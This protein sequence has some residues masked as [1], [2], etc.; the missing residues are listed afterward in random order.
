MK[1]W[2]I[3]ALRKIMLISMIAITILFSTPN[4][5]KAAI[6]DDWGGTLLDAV[7]SLF[8]AFGDTLTN[9]MEWA[10]IGEMS[11]EFD[12]SD[13]SW[14]PL[15]SE[16]EQYYGPIEGYDFPTEYEAATDI[17]EGSGGYRVPCIDYS[18]RE[19][20]AGVIPA[21]DINFISPNYEGDDRAIS[22]QLQTT[23][24][25]WYVG[26]R[27]FSLL[28][29]MVVLVYVGIRMMLTSLAAEKAKYKQMFLDWLIAMCLIFFLHYIMSFTITMVET[30]TDA[31]ATNVSDINVYVYPDDAA[32]DVAQSTGEKGNPEAEFSTNLTGLA[33]FR[34]Q[35]SSG[36]AKFMYLI[37]YTALVIYTLMFTITYL[38]RVLIMAFLTLVAPLV[39]MTYPIDKIGD[40][41]AQ[42]FSFWLK[43]YI[44]NALLQPFH[45]LLYAIF[46]GSAFDLATKNVIYSLVALGF[47]FSAEK[48]LR[49]MFGF[50][51]SG[52]IGTLGAF[53][54]GA[55][56]SKMIDTMGKVRGPNTQEV[57]Q[58]EKADKIKP[59]NFSNG[60]FM[61]GNADMDENTVPVIHGSGIPIPGLRGETTPVP[62]SEMTTT[63]N[64]TMGNST[65][66]SFTDSLR[67][68]QPEESRFAPGTA[69]GGKVKG[70][71]G[72]VKGIL[73]AS[74]RG[75]EGVAN[76]VSYQAGRSIKNAPKTLGKG[77]KFVGKTALRAG[78]AAGAGSIGLAAGIATGDL[79]NAI[80][81]GV[82][83]VVAGGAAGGTAFNYGEKGV[84]SAWQGAKDNIITPY[85]EGALGI[86]EVKAQRAFRDLNTQDTRNFVA[87]ETRDE[88]TGEYL[89]EEEITARIQEMAEIQQATGVYGKDNLL[90]ASDLRRATQEK[91]RQ[92][93]DA[94]LIEDEKWLNKKANISKQEI[95]ELLQ[96]TEEEKAQLRVAADPMRNKAESEMNA[97]EKKAFK[98]NVRQVEALNKME[99]L[100]NREMLYKKAEQL[101]NDETNIATAMASQTRGMAEEEKVQYI[102][103][104]CMRNG[105]TE[106]TAKIAT[107]RI[108]SNMDFL[109]GAKKN[110]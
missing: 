91:Y 37:I 56:V 73:G 18:P 63:G 70:I 71:P 82:A 60:A 95:D 103:N 23:I 24:A 88:D 104:R 6:M 69:E 1:R 15:V 85:Q 35:Y 45:L 75:L 48:I 27:N 107:N 80:Q 8:A 59:L 47:I 53:A 3:N 106:Q 30:L 105:H 62:G 41:K 90:I 46:I 76:H 78:L 29:L 97:T 93:V 12:T 108:M 61:A 109:D 20:F 25:S 7:V 4:Y 33:R 22:S 51:K 54:G 94:D 87:E 28:I 26:L 64:T 102:Y 98:K 36:M 86:K 49:N 81:M 96:M 44:F 16:P 101:A 58:K 68:V 40:G 79:D 72:M 66:L 89:S 65:S 74:Y 13:F 21:L 57:E 67:N 92:Q 55:F 9:I 99:K 100:Q 14:M 84:Q 39:C 5:A 31:L 32:R 43:E 2:T 11:T 10:I 83:G 19:I 50:E 38:K 17:E 34:L 77:A 52:T 42:A 110:V